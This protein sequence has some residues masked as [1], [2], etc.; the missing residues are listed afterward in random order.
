MISLISHLKL[1]WKAMAGCIMERK[2]VGMEIGMVIA[3][4]NHGTAVGP[5]LVQ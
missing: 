4:L 2:D 1:Q 5:R 3:E